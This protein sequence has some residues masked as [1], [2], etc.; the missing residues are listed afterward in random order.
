MNV[1]WR[2]FLKCLGNRNKEFKFGIAFS[3]WLATSLILAGCSTVPENHETQT[4][5][6]AIAFSPED[7]QA[8]QA[9]RVKRFQELSSRLLKASPKLYEYLIKRQDVPSLP[10]DMPVLR[11][12]FEEKVFFDTALWDIRPDANAVLDVVAQALKKETPNAVLFVA[13]HTDSRGS[14]EYNLDLSVKRANSVAEGLISRGVGPVKI[15]RVGFGK[16]VPLRPNDS[17]ANMALNRRVEFILSSKLDAAVFFLKDQGNLNCSEQ[18]SADTLRCQ[19]PPGKKK[20]IAVPVVAKRTGPSVT[21]DRI[22]QKL[23]KLDLT[24]NPPT[25]RVG[26]PKR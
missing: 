17:E 3:G 20:F 11:V 23:P 26:A 5:V 25:K 16:A 24:L 6:G 1:G 12:V 14:E 22:I 19:E 18:T 9:N 13:G 21:N 4:D 7:F 2:S 10:G 8:E 15:W